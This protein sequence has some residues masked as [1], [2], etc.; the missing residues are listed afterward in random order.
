MTTV[1]DILAEDLYPAI[2]F[3][4]GGTRLSANRGQT[5]SMKSLHTLPISLLNTNLTSCFT[6][7]NMTMRFVSE[8]TCFDINDML[9]Y[10][11]LMVI[12]LRP[13]TQGVNRKVMLLHKP[14]RDW[15]THEGTYHSF[16]AKFAASY[17]V[18]GSY[19]I[20]FYYRSITVCYLTT[21]TYCPWT[22]Q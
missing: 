7:Y 19:K 4:Y 16:N 20:A 22:P 14:R 18:F 12:L 6:S 1:G 8:R 3:P 15:E 9:E 10:T 13:G 11:P 2:F 17:L 21:S 5:T